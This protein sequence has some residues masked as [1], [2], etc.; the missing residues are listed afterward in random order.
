MNKFQ[1][2]LSIKDNKDNIQVN[3]D[4]E[5]TSDGVLVGYFSQEPQWYRYTIRSVLG[6]LG[7]WK[8][9]PI[10]KAKARAILHS[11]RKT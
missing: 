4:L 6:S 8:F 9:V 3:L 1:W 5:R 2:Y 11:F 10:S 7:E